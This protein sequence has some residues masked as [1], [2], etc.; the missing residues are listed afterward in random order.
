MKSNKTLMILL[1]VPFLIGLLS[2]TSILIIQNT[3]AAD[4]TDILWSYRENEGFKIQQAGYDLE[5]TAVKNDKLVLADGNELVWSLS[6]LDGEEGVASLEDHGEGKATLY[7]RKEGKV[8]LTCSNARKTKAK[9]FVAVIFENGAIVINPKRAGS[10]VS[11]SGTTYIGE[12]DLSYQKVA[13]DSATLKNATFELVPTLYGDSKLAYTEAISRNVTIKGNTI[14]VLSSGEGKVRYVLEGGDYRDYD[15]LVPPDSVNVYSYN[16]LLLATNFSSKGYSPVLQ[17]NLQSLQNTYEYDAEKKVYLVDKP[18]KENTALFGNYNPNYKADDPNSRRF[19]FDKEVY[20]F[21][22]TYNTSFIDQYN[23]AYPDSHFSKDVLAAI[24]LTKSLYGNGFTINAHELCFPVEGYYAKNGKLTPGEKDLFKGPLPFLAVGPMKLPVIK[25]FGQDNSLIYA[26]G[27]DISIVDVELRNTNDLNNLYD[28]TYTGS[29][30]D[31][32]GPNFT[33]KNSVLSHGRTILRAYDTENLLVENAILKMANEFIAM[34]GSEK[35]IPYEEDKKVQFT[36]DDVSVNMPF[37][38]FFNPDGGEGTAD[39]ILTN[40]LMEAGTKDPARL[41]RASKLFMAIQEALDSAIPENAYAYE[42]TM[43]NVSFEKSGVFSI[44][45]ESAFN[46][47]YLYGGLPSAVGNLVGSLE[48]SLK[49]SKIGGSAAPVKLHLDGCKFFDWKKVDTIDVSSLVEENFAQFLEILGR[50]DIKVTIDDFFPVKSL[51]NDLA[52][53]GR[54]L[55]SHEG[56]KYLN[57]K[58]AWYG[59]GKNDSTVLID[60]ET[61]DEEAIELDLREPMYSGRY[62]KVQHPI[63]VLASNAILAA[64]GYHPFR[65]YVNDRIVSDKAPENFG[66]SPSIEDIYHYAISQGGK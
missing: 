44:A 19:S 21:P 54:Y 33:L 61:K 25:A 23:A 18:L 52:K 60:S 17:K 46:G 50:D 15:F 62:S 41:D 30:L 26:D 35:T 27:K 31:V 43:K 40:L 2:F 38:D 8:R 39:E 9:S 22:S 29:V 55:Y 51:L 13:L 4:I 49:P 45:F 66:L 36:V 24:H 53:E 5:A 32:H 20:R 6:P 42:G 3:V 16:D 7:A 10:G 14:T 1:L 28:L 48:G 63:M 65:F 57:T 37:K 34:L 12:K 58:V 11:L 47:P 56:E 59:G 64:I